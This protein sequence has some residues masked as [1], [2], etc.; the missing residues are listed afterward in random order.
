MVALA[1]MKETEMIKQR[2]KKE[3]EEIKVCKSHD[4]FTTFCV[5][6]FIYI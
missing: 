1:V 4:E 6:I 2:D 5:S 3:K